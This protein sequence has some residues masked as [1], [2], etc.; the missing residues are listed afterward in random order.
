ML[1]PKSSP[2]HAIS[3]LVLKRG[4]HFVEMVEDEEFAETL[5]RRGEY[6]PT[7][8]V[9]WFDAGEPLACVKNASEAAQRIPSATI[10]I[11]LGLHYADGAGGGIYWCRHTYL[12]VPRLGARGGRAIYEVTVGPWG[13]YGFLATPSDWRFWVHYAGGTLADEQMGR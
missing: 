13:Y 9:A 5:L 6:R 8:D 10:H 4:G 11:G 2:W 12:T 1:L 3:K 7:T